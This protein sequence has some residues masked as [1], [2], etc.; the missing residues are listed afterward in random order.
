MNYLYATHLREVTCPECGGQA[1][2]AQ[3]PGKP[4]ISHILIDGKPYVVPPG[5]EEPSR[6]LL[7]GN[8]KNGH[9]VRFEEDDV[10]LFVHPVD[11]EWMATKP[12]FVG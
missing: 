9:A 2:R 8:C 4:S 11:N 6:L 10:E 12:L 3:A 1:A 5:G 7:L